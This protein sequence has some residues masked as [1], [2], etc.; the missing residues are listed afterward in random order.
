MSNTKQILALG[1]I[2]YYLKFIKYKEKYNFVVKIKLLG[3]HICVKR[4]VILNGIK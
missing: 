1:L 4:E 3:K 2:L